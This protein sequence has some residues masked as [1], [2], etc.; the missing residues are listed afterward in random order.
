MV[1]RARKVEVVGSAMAE[2]DGDVL[3]EARIEAVDLVEIVQRGNRAA[4]AEEA[5]VLDSVRRKEADRR[6]GWERW[7]AAGKVPNRQSREIQAA[8]AAGRTAATEEDRQ[9]AEVVAG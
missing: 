5:T 9:L 3:M 7:R 2:V 4:R 8:V 1:L 6:R